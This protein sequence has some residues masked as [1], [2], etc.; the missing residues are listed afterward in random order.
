MRPDGACSDNRLEGWFGCSAK[1][2]DSSVLNSARA[3]VTLQDATGM[4]LDSTERVL[5]PPKVAGTVQ[6]SVTDWERRMDILHGKGRVAARLSR[7]RRP[8]QAG[9][10]E[11]RLPVQGS[12]QLECD[13]CGPWVTFADCAR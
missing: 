6:L 4:S 3:P 11:R 1:V 9:W 12:V 5:S 13:C 10:L 8:A 7:I 2:S